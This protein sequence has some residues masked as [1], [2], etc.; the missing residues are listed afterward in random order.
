MPQIQP[1]REQVALRVS[2]QAGLL[3]TE[4]KKWILGLTE[5]LSLQK[6]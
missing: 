2:G 4:A 3:D 6:I 5:H 1:F